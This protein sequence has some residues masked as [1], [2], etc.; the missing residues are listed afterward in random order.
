M[1]SLVSPERYVKRELGTGLV[2]RM[3]PD[4]QLR[5][6]SLAR[7]WGLT[8]VAA[9]G[10]AAIRYADETAII[11]DDGTLTFA[12]VERRT[13][14]LARSLRSLG[15]RDGSRVGV[16]CR[17]HRGVVEVMVACSKL[18]ADVV[19]HDVKASP[20]ELAGAA[21]R[22][23][24]VLLVHDEDAAAQADVVSP[25]GPRVLAW[26]EPARRRVHATLDELICDAG[27]E[28]LGCATRLSNAVVFTEPHALRPDKMIPCSLITPL[29]ASTRLPMRRR[30]TVLIGAPVGGPWGFLH[31]LISMRLFAT[32]ALTRRFDPDGVLDR[33]ERLGVNVAAFTPP[34]IE[35]IV[36]L[37]W[38]RSLCHDTS[39][40]RV[41]SVPGPFLASSVAMPAI[42]R[43]GQVLHNLRGTT[44]ISVDPALWSAAT[45]RI[46][47]DR[48][49]HGFSALTA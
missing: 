41:I 11:D 36:L 1:R 42:E 30:D 18:G 49:V 31:A 14:A 24:T 19:Y 40:L 38:A 20:A 34:M 21:R 28:S 39:S 2:P 16:L 37:P 35:Q 46:R 44:V 15:V 6:R 9:Y 48:R 43:F 13:N 22:R 23:P 7:R 29:V 12:E 3:R 5:A 45:R 4:H 8:P 17:N 10:L 26:H 27:D 25:A 32:I 33:V 47:G